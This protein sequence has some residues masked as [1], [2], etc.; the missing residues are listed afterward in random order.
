MRSESGRGK[1]RRLATS[2]PATMSRREAI[3]S[4]GGALLVAAVGR[5]ALGKSGTPLSVGNQR[6]VQRYNR[7]RR[8]VQTRHGRI[9][10]VD[11][12]QGAAV[13]LLHGF[14]LN[15]FQWRGTIDRLCTQR[16][17]LAP[18]FMGL[19]FTEVASGQ[20]V[21]PAAQAEMINAFLDALGIRQVDIIANDSGG[22]VAQLF[23]SKYGA[24][25]RTLLL[26]NCDVE[27]DCPPESVLPVIDLAR[28]GLYTKLYLRPWL[29][30]KE[31]LR[32]SS[33]FGRLC[34]SDPRNP[35]D[36]AIEQYL[37]PLVSS[38]EREA[39]TNRFAASL[40][41][42]PLAG[43]TESLRR[44]QVPTRIAW[45]MSDEIFST[46]NIEY[47]V[48]V[49]PRV[50]GIRK[51]PGAKLFFPEEL[52]DVIAEEATTLWMDQV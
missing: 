10:Y 2:Q 16:R 20:S 1:A 37:G 47:L 28:G 9:A 51:I 38:P 26:T 32:A 25:A 11:R 21:S 5:T 41:P 35:T 42:N 27:T 45:G 29:A 46:G 6:E 50:T 40:A 23:I 33:D 17:C 36:T 7:E 48:S 18:D 22:A 12:G 39:L 43:I 30:D 4:A 44:C 19:G 52:P 14:P 31:M 8:Y 49:L 24:R 3:V 13:L 15:G 34:Y